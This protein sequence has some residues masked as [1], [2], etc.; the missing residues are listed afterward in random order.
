MWVRMAERIGT[1]LR[2]EGADE[3]QRAT[4]CDTF[5]RWAKVG[6]ADLEDEAERAKAKLMNVDRAQE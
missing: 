6:G 4:D 5:D 3:G 2:D 1:R